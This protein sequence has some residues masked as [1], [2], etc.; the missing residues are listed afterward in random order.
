M[1]E[2]ARDDDIELEVVMAIDRVVDR[3]AVVESVMAAMR[4]RYDLSSAR[5][6]IE[7]GFEEDPHPSWRAIAEHRI[8]DIGRGLR[9]EVENAVRREIV[10]RLREDTEGERE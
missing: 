3:G 9:G 7:D 10:T 5:S 4:D 2:Q 1:A 8:K 6:W